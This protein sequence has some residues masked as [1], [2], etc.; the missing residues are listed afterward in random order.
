MIRQHGPRRTWAFVSTVVFL[1]GFLIVSAAHAAD[2]LPIE[3]AP[4][5]PLPLPPRWDPVRNGQ[6]LYGANLPWDH[7]GSD[8]GFNRWGYRGLANQGPSG[9]RRET[10]GNDQGA[11][12]LFW[13]VR[14]G[15]DHCLGVQVHL[16]GGA[17]NPHSSALVFSRFD[18]SAAQPQDATVNLT[19]QTIT[20]RV[21]LPSAIQGPASARSGVILFFQDINWIWAQTPWMNIETTNTWITLTV[22]GDDL[23]FNRTRVRTIGIK[24][25]GN[26]FATS[27]A[28]SGPAFVDEVS[29]SISPDIRFDFP[30]PDTRTEQELKAF[31]GLRADDIPGLKIYVARWWLIADGRAGLT[32]DSNGFVTG[33]DDRFLSDIRELLR[34][35]KSARVY[36]MPVLL[37][38]LL[39]GE[40]VV[41]DGVQT[42]GRADLINNPL[43]RRSLLDNALARIFEE[44]S[45]SNEVLVIDLFN[46]PEWLLIDHPEVTIPPGKRPP[47]IKAGGVVDLD[48]MT[49]F[50]SEI[51]ELHKQKTKPE[52]NPL[53]T[54]GSA[55]QRWV[56]V[57]RSLPLDM[58]QFHLWNSPGQI[59]EGLNLPYP[60]PVV[61]VPNI[62]GEFSTLPGLPQAR[63]DVFKSGLTNGYSGAFPWAYRAKDTASLPLLGGET[64]NCFKSLPRFT[65]TDDPIVAGI[66]PVRAIHI[67]E[68]RVSVD[69]LR[70]SCNLE[71]YS[72]TGPSPVAGITTIQAAH[73]AEPR[74]ALDEY[75][76]CRSVPRPDYPFPRPAPQAPVMS[77]HLSETRAAAL[78]VR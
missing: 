72:Y 16:V 41:V 10:R 26:S 4:T 34:L 63:C 62:L 24:I 30:E 20:A 70:L 52:K 1:S 60:P 49:T 32:Y 64:G 28:Y 55:S 58:A 42:F 33:L 50:F 65:F 54:V 5:P 66:S 14:Q 59:D 37:D 8:F 18:E 17:P 74:T 46:E 38:F 67:K 31:A 11:E 2:P 29:V 73:F 48:T 71:P 23:P 22:R 68:L 35:A 69:A 9:W 43:K 44:F 12:R 77:R 45:D 36:L 78:T 19:N 15:A 13:A 40:P 39:A 27:F 53:L 75:Y 7:Y 61:G 76:D 25:G 6:P 3:V 47:E 57:W 56:G 51:I 21:Y